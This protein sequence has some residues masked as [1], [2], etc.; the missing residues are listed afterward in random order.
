MICCL[1][2]IGATMIAPMAAARSEV[3]LQLGIH[4]AQFPIAGR[5][6]VSYENIDITVYIS[7]GNRLF[8]VKQV[9]RANLYWSRNLVVKS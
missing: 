3:E 8:K 9:N 7:N 4:E 6:F 2:I 5:N 1:M